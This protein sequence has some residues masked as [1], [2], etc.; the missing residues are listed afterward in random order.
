MPAFVLDLK[1][2][3][4]SANRSAPAR[5]ASDPAEHVVDVIGAVAGPRPYIR[6]S[7]RTCGGWPLG[8]A[9]AAYAKLVPLPPEPG[10]DRGLQE[11]AA[12]LTQRVVAIPLA[13]RSG[14]ALLG[15]L[16]G[17]SDELR[18]HASPVDVEAEVAEGR[19]SAPVGG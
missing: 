4:P 7:A 12:R 16:A 3:R 10:A 1:A 2:Q 19:L 9:V 6:I 11:H 8:T 15:M 13:H 17:V 18:E 5:R 14:S